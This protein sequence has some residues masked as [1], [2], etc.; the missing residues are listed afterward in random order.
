MAGTRAE[1]HCLNSG[2]HSGKT[3]CNLCSQPNKK[4]HGAKSG[5]LDTHLHDTSL[6]P[7]QLIHLKAKY[8]QVVL[9]SHM[10]A[11]K[12]SILFEDWGRGH[13]SMSR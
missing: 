11:R 10:D 3:A 5:D 12:H 8:I 13:V 4:L 2:K 1:N 7:A 9:N 6:A